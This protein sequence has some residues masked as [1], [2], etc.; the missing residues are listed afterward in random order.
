M[1]SG[2]KPWLGFEK[3]WERVEFLFSLRREVQVYP[4]N[5]GLNS[6]IGN[7]FYEIRREVAKREGDMTERPWRRG[8]AACPGPG[9]LSK[10]GRPKHG[11]PVPHS[12]VW[13]SVFW[14]KLSREA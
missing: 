4:L 1:R 2:G 7:L 8:R 14:Q 3:V 10:A 9:G 11:R 13:A 5:V 6:W 12:K